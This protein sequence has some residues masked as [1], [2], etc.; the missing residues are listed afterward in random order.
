LVVFWGHLKD[1][2]KKYI[3]VLVDRG[4]PVEM[5][6]GKMVTRMFGFFIFGND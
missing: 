3:K 2:R 5:K 4:F 6:V 1:R